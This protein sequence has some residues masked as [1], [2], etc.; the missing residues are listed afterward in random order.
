MRNLSRRL[1]LLADRRR[2]DARRVIDSLDGC[3]D[4][5]DRRQHI[6]RRLT[7]RVHLL[8]DRF[9]GLG[10][11]LR[12]HLH[13]VGHHGESA[14]VLTGAGGLDGGVQGE[15]VRLPG[16]LADQTN[17]G[18]DLLRRVTQP[19]HRIDRLLG[20]RHRATGQLGR[21]IRLTGDF[22]RRAGQ[23]LTGRSHGAD[24][25]RRLLGG[26]RH[27]TGEP[28]GL[29][30]I[31]PNAARG[32]I[33]PGGGTRHRIRGLQ[34]PTGDAFSLRLELRD[35]RRVLLHLQRRPVDHFRRVAVGS[36]NA[37]HQ[38]RPVIET[39]AAVIHDRRG[40]ANVGIRNVQHV[41]DRRAQPGEVAGA[42][43][44]GDARLQITSG[45]T[46][47]NVGDRGQLM[48]DGVGHGRSGSRVLH[49]KRRRPGACVPKG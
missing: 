12:K 14:S 2:D 36:W 39:A 30:R 5:L 45:G 38:N 41:I 46:F 23:L 25:G 43:Q 40:F 18:L 1:R 42:S 28:L 44:T 11:V 32:G 3:S 17:H 10:G 29:H 20:L 15:Q 9:R 37:P 19:L 31:L 4:A 26:S 34:H 48:S 13:L 27:R 33:Q 49:I 8:G 35:L 47:A 21:F 24:V 16:N 22:H 7:H 6:R